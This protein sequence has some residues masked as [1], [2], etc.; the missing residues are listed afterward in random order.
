MAQVNL[1]AVGTDWHTLK[2]GLLRGT[3]RLVF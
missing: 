2:L 1:P 3:D